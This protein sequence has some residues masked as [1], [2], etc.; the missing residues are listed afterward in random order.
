[1]SNW[2]SHGCQQ[3]KVIAFDGTIRLWS[4]WKRKK[5]ASWVAAEKREENPGSSYMGRILLGMGSAGLFCQKP[6]RI[7]SQVV[8]PLWV[9]PML[10]ARKRLQSRHIHT[11]LETMKGLGEKRAILIF[12]WKKKG[13]KRPSL[14]ISFLGCQIFIAHY[15]FMK[16]G[17]FSLPGIYDTHLRMFMVFLFHR[18]LFSKTGGAAALA[19]KLKDCASLFMW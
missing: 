6:G 7:F 4:A 19:Y 16:H 17:V 8:G 18:S 15:G 2:M 9:L 1:M 13:N 5:A 14:S 10:K 12:T 3:L 11:H